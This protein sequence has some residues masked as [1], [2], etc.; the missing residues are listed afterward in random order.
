MQ[1]PSQNIPELDHW[2]MIRENRG[3]ERDTREKG[4]KRE[5]REKRRLRG[6][7]VTSGTATPR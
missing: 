2:E 7:G 5:A 4:L 6:K 1:I 3:W